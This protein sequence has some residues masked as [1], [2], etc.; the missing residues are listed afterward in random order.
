MA[1]LKEKTLQAILD[2]VQWQSL[3]KLFKPH[4]G[5]EQF[6]RSEGYLP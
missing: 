1:N 6:L 4:Q 2:D 3:K 5:M